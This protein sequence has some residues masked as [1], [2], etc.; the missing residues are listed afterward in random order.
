MGIERVA[1]VFTGP[2]ARASH[3]FP[4]DRFGTQFRLGSSIYLIMYA[5]VLLSMI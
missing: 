4:F 2:Y 3:I 5:L 1:E